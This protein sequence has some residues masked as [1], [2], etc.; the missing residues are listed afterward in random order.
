MT[1]VDFIEDMQTHFQGW[2]DG[3]D[4]AAFDALIAFIFVIFIWIIFGFL[5]F[6]YWAKKLALIPQTH[7][8]MLVVAI[9]GPLSHFIIPWLYQKKE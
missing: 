7:W 5:S 8:F 6:C 1:T 4:Q 9:F 2:I 3:F